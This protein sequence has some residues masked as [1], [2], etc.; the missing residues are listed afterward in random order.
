MF[1]DGKH[2]RSKPFLSF[3]DETKKKHGFMYYW[4]KDKESFSVD[5]SNMNDN[6]IGFWSMRIVRNNMVRVPNNG[7]PDQP[8]SNIYPLRAVNFSGISTFV[9]N[10]PELYCDVQYGKGKWRKELTCKKMSY[11]KCVT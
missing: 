10:K 11:R 5:F 7:S 1:V 3:L 9:P 4:R 8:Y 2:I 6:G